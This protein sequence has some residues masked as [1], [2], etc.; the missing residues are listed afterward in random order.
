[1]PETTQQPHKSAVEGLKITHLLRPHWGSL[2]LALIAVLGETAADLLEPWPLKIVLDYVVQSKHMPHWLGVAVNW[3]TGQSKLAVLNFAVVAVAV[4][5][6][7]GA[8][9]SYSEKYL[10][11]SVGQWVMHDLRRTLYHHIHRLSLSQ[12]DEKRTGDLITR[13]TSDIEAIQ[14]FITSALLGTAVNVFTLVGMIAVMFYLN[15]QFTLIALSIAPALFAVVYVYTRRIKSASREVRKK[16]SEL[17]SVVQEV[18]SSIR[19]V[20]AFAREDYEQRRFEG[21]SLQSVE[22]ALRAR[23]IKARLSPFVDVI[24]A[25]GTCLVLG[26]G[27]R[28]I[29]AGKLSAGSLV[30]FFL[31]LSKMYKPMRE[32]S[33]MTDT[34]SKAAVGYERIKEVLETESRVRDLPRAR[35]APRFRGKIEFDRVSFGYAPDAPVL[36][37]VS[38]KIEAGQ[39]AA[40]V[41]P[42]GAGKSTI[43]SLIARFYDPISGAVKIDGADVRSYTLKSLRRQMSFV[44]Q[45]TLLFH[46]PLWQNI[47][48]GK[49][50]ADRA[51]IIRAAELANAHEFIE[52]M[53]EGYDTMVG[54]RGVTLSGGQRQRIA[55]ARAILRDSPI[56]ILDEP[57]SNLDASS[58]QLVIEALGRLMEGKTSIVIAH[59]L[60][61]IQRADV[62]FVVKDFTIAERGTHEELLSRGGVYSE[63]YN[64]QT[65]GGEGTPGATSP[66]GD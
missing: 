50:E 32:L 57:T 64:I 58:E 53:P 11:T 61:T 8:V 26:F 60:A 15:W 38:F 56:L 48:Y 54:E 42:T 49:P 25:V 28:L 33:K 7:V 66:A 62:I 63:F 59:H 12:H 16:E 21:H 37:D 13:V 52:K 17:V 31:Y 22:L 10:T 43:V 27:A 5:A 40:L 46:A 45:E 30:V 2:S 14:D 29:L 39:T 6:L 34:I 55:I 35:Q 19:V 24:V 65:S 18:F 23:S 3:T 47:A 36:K 41:G 1:M 51:A 44:L 20:Q 9:S 4:I